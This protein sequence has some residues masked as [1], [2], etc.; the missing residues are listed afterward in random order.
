MSN[1]S[2]AEINQQDFAGLEHVETLDL[3]GNSI[4]EIDQQGFAGLDNVKTLDLSQNNIAEINQQ[5]FAGLE[6]VPTLDLS[7]NNIT[8]TV[9]ADGLGQFIGSNTTVILKG[10]PAG[11]WTGGRGNS[12]GIYVDC[13]WHDLTQVPVFINP[14]VTHMYVQT[15][16][17][18]MAL[19]AQHCAVWYPSNHDSNVHTLKYVPSQICVG[20]KHSILRV[21]YVK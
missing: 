13:T 4:T 2:I 6:N 1:N 19:H 14:N 3:S 20:N 5:D 17:S 16:A 10:N 9:A 18:E 8:S 11:C 15:Q 7:N 21:V 12:S